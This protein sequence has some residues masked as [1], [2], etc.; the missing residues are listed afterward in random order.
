M[1]TSRAPDAD[2]PARRRSAEPVHGRERPLP[3]APPVPPG[4]RPDVLGGGRGRAVGGGLDAVR[5][6]PRRRARPA[7]VARAG[8]AGALHAGPRGTA[9]AGLASRFALSSRVLLCLA[10]YILLH[11]S[12]G[13]PV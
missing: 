8:G 2:A 12:I 9:P 11:A 3:E 5:R 7:R 13:I 1:F 6:L 4:R 10:G